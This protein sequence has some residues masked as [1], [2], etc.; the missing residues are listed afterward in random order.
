MCVWGGERCLTCAIPQK[1]WSKHPEL[2]EIRDKVLSAFRHEQ[3]H[4][5]G[6]FQFVFYPE[7]SEGG[8][9][10]KFIARLIA[11]DEVS[12]EHRKVIEGCMAQLQRCDFTS[13]PF[14]PVSLATWKVD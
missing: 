12:P 5:E 9:V 3:L 6:V 10:S 13:H 8:S 14:Y 7:M 4:G 11:E 1:Q 2:E